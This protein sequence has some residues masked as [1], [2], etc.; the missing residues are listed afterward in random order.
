MNT[1]FRVTRASALALLG[2]LAVLAMLTVYEVLATKRASDSLQD[3]E[4]AR[5]VANAYQS[6]EMQVTSLELT[7]MKL[8][9]NNSPALTA[10]LSEQVDRVLR[11]MRAIRT[12]GND[13]DRAIVDEMFAN[14]LGAMRTL[15]MAVR[16]GINLSSVR[17][18]LPD[19]ATA[20]AIR[21]KFAEQTT[22]RQAEAD[23]L[24]AEYRHGQDM[25][26]VVT[27]VLNLAGFVMVLILGV[28]LWH[29][30]RREARIA[31]MEASQDELEFAR[32]EADRANQA[33]SQFLSRMSHELRTPMNAVLGFGQLLE[34]DDLT[35]TQR[36]NVAYIMRAGR[37]L[38]RLI[39]EVLDISRIEAGRL[40]LSLE[41]F[42]IS[43]VVKEVL[44]MNAPMAAQA[45]ITIEC[46]TDEHDDWRAIGDVQRTK[47]VLLNLVSNA[48]KYNVPG[49]SM[50]IYV[51]SGD[52][53][54]RIAVED[55]G[56]GISAEGMAR[57]FSPFDRLGA[58]AT[59]VEGTGLGLALSKALMEAMG[60][61]LEVATVQ[62]Q[63]STFTIT[64]PAASA[65]TVAP[66]GTDENRER[67]ATVGT[68]VC[69]E[70]NTASYHVIEGVLRHLGVECA[71][72]S[73]V[74]DGL[75]QVLEVKPGMV[76]VDLH[77]EGGDGGAVIRGLRG[78][79]ETW[80]LPIIV[81]SADTTEHTR[82]A[83]LGLGADAFIAKPVDFAELVET[84]TAL[85]EHRKDQHRAA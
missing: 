61:R 17:D 54:M 73:T 52:G 40:A 25:R 33:K 59:A 36:E 6:A 75:Q 27:S 2:I 82:R 24:L 41:P 71:R 56:P 77:L 79:P 42:V 67:L 48:V 12:I 1:P 37:H 44:A 30:S 63:G 53:E 32:F 80:D 69:V 39:D 22:V 84:M 58:D 3:V 68:V 64:L 31:A 35:E 26:L 15:D 11:E 60:G 16:A 34:M 21:G 72:A 83:V 4:R 13:T 8:F 66:A 85:V 46:C 29:Y 76:L 19:E 7:V 18:R 20:P 9:D 81:I 57:L 55:T 74:E 23:Q 38:L 51:A 78:H 43:D 65:A 62:G 50:R 14:Y 28:G 10:T 5:D 49:G 70:D 47:Q 45:G